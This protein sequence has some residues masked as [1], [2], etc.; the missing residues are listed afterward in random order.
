[1]SKLNNRGWGLR[2]MIF[3][4]GILVLFFGIAIFFIY[5]FYNDF[6][7]EERNTVNYEVTVR[8]VL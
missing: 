3:L 4:M 6:R 5:K 2:M 8:S 7:I 1:M